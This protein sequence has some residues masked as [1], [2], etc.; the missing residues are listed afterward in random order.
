MLLLPLTFPLVLLPSLFPVHAGVQSQ[1]STSLLP[2]QPSQGCQSMGVGRGCGNDSA[3]HGLCPAILPAEHPIPMPMCRRSQLLCLMWS[4][5]WTALGTDKGLLEGGASS[6]VRSPTEPSPKKS[7]RCC[8]GFGT[9]ELLFCVQAPKS[10]VRGLDPLE[11]FFW[12]NLNFLGH[13]DIGL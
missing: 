3:Q 10:H 12:N 4:K 13:L 11:D 6:L 8:W 9:A 2:R 1:T 7:L 5:T